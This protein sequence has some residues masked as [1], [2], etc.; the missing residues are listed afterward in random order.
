MQINATQ[1]RE[2]MILEINSELYRVLSTMHRTPGKG[3][4]CMQTRLK[5]IQNGKNLEKRFL[6]SERVEKAQLRTKKMQYLYKENNDYIFM[7][8]ETF[9]QLPLDDEMLGGGKNFL[10]DGEEYP[11]TFHEE[12]PVGIEL[13]TTVSLKVT[14]APPVIKK[15][16]ATSSMSP[17]ELENGMTVNAPG[18]VKEGDVIKIN[19]ETME[20]IERVNR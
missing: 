13:P 9:D 15:A 4:A 5:N 11:V 18:F 12:N 8:T 3:N 20:Y 7:D 16:T 19:I 14:T 17:V 10:I 6:S 2:G 1:I